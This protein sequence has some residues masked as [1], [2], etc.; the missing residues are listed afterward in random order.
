LAEARFMHSFKLI[1]VLFFAGLLSGLS[2]C[3]VFKSG[4]KPVELEIRYN[5]GNYINY[6]KN[7]PVEIYVKYSN[8]KEKE[9]TGKDELTV[10]AAGA[11]YGNGYVQIDAYPK[12]ITSNQIKISATY[13]KDEVTLK[14][15]VT[16][17]FN[18]KGDIEIAFTGRQGS[19][20]STGENG[21]TP[22]LF[23]DGKEGG[24][25][26]PGGDGGSGDNLTL[27]VWKDSMEFYYI[28]V[29]NL[30]TSQTYIYKIKKSDYRFHMNVSGGQGGTGGKG[31]QGGDG[32]DGSNNN[33]KL[34]A[35]GNGGMGGT[36]G[37]GGTGGK[38]GNIYV[39]IH[40][41][42]AEIQHIFTCNNFGGSGGYGGEGGSGG[43]G[44]T[45]LE[46]QTAGSAGVNGSKGTSGY[47]GAAGDVFT[48]LI[49]NFDIEY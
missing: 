13:T 1:L 16:I 32:K 12:K 17:P 39:F 25:G 8:G 21:V 6:G 47:N 33:N 23:R 29:N 34:K 5:D 2:G 9:V 49:E 18:Y 27:Y 11:F 28:R 30:T 15:E 42:A 22:L 45:P 36:G 24:S 44:G 4:K 14:D 40:P 43:R 35:P 20:G 31:G 37:I 48:I 10:T 7:F 26:G 46:G 19:N 38:G 41:N 3:A